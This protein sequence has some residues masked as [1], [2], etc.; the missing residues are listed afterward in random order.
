[1]RQGTPEHLGVIMD[2]N[3]R[4]AR[5]HNLQSIARGHERGAEKFFELCG[6]CVEEGIPFL[7]VY[8]F[9]TENWGRGQSEV[10]CLMRL[11][12]TLFVE[13]I[14]ACDEKNIRVRMIG[15]R[16]RLDEEARRVIAAAEERTERNTALSLHIAFSY[17]GRDEIVRAARRLCRDALEGTI[18]PGGIDEDAVA[19]RLDTAGVPDVDLVIRTGG[20]RRLSN[21]LPWQS[22]YAEL[23]FVDALWPDFSRE[24]FMD[25][26]AHYRNAAANHGR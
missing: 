15:N 6:W 4:W 20:Q 10:D 16:D 1:M 22:A 11:M 24:L 3:R 2:G 7:S 5:R 21:F 12:K 14:A 23:H 26:I 9:S 19:A 17:G 13:R 8:A 18:A 25:A